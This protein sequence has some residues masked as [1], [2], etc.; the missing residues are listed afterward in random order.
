M[1]T[2]IQALLKEMDQEST[3][4]RKMLQCIPEDRL[5]WQPHE[6]SMTIR[7]LATHLAELPTWVTMGFTTD[8]LDFAKGNYEATEVKSKEELIKL[9]E[10]S[11]ADGRTHL[12]KASETQFPEAWVMRNG[13]AVLWSTTRAEVIRHTYCQIVHH[14][15][16]LGVFLRLL[17]IPIPG[18]YGPSADEN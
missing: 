12:E 6:K 9:F 13:E 7:R 16:Q 1:S 5:D 8:E 15:A 4:T 17:D 11:L 10:D 2:I 18:S 3:T 14:R